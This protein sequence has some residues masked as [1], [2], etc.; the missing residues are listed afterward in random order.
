MYVNQ[1]EPGI[2][3]YNKITIIVSWGK[4]YT[5]LQNRKTHIACYTTRQQQHTQTATAGLDLCAAD[6]HT[7]GLKAQYSVGLVCSV[8]G[9]SAAYIMWNNKDDKFMVEYMQ[10]R[11]VIGVITTVIYLFA[12]IRTALSKYTLRG[13]PGEFPCSVMHNAK[14]G[15]SSGGSPAP[16]C[17]RMGECL[18]CCISAIE[19]I[20]PGVVPAQCANRWKYNF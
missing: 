2:Q 16:P 6:I 12:L 17:V 18:L 3:K 9:L 1:I 5:T 4:W 19:S 14:R 7:A 15:S 10:M 11:Y 8:V 20:P 13:S